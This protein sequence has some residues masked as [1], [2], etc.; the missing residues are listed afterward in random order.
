VTSI[1]KGKPP[2]AKPTGKPFRAFRL[3]PEEDDK[4]TKLAQR[5]G[6]SRSEVLRQ[7]LNYIWNQE[8]GH[9][10]SKGGAA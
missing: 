8:C 10:A 3:D 2:K 1:I 5:H 6:I 9:V 7:A 4:L